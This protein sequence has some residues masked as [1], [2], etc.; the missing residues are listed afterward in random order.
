ARSLTLNHLDP[1]HLSLRRRVANLE[2]AENR[3]YLAGNN[4]LCAHNQSAPADPQALSRALAAIRGLIRVFIHEAQGNVTSGIVL[5]VVE[6]VEANL[7]SAGRHE[8]YAAWLNKVRRRIG[9][10]AGALPEE[11]V[12]DFVHNLAFVEYDLEE[13]VLARARRREDAAEVVQRA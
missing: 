10:R 11:V 12:A 1:H 6:T 3:A 2:I 8:Q 5:S 13:N 9:E 4:R 7:R